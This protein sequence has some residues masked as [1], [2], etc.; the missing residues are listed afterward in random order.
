[1]TP[2]QCAEKYI[3]CTRS[4]STL[5]VRCLQIRYNRRLP[6]ARPLQP[7]AAAKIRGQTHID[8][9]IGTGL[10]RVKLFASAAPASNTNSTCYTDHQQSADYCAVSPTFV[11]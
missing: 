3:I 2:T 5:A 9:W 11:M 10:L 4:L 6:V 1:M 8:R 7:F